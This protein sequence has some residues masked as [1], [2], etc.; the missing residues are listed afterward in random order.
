MTLKLLELQA[1]GRQQEFPLMDDK[2]GF[3]QSTLCSDRTFMDSI[4][5]INPLT[6]SGCSEL[7]VIKVL[8]KKHRRVKHKVND[9]QVC[10]LDSTSCTVYTSFICSIDTD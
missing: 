3:M 5:L 9:M 2:I 6:H 10:I 1:G 7:Q 4:A 8:Q